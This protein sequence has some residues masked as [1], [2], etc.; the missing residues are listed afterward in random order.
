[1]HVYVFMCACNVYG[2][3]GEEAAVCVCVDDTQGV[4][5]ESWGSVNILS[6]VMSFNIDR[7]QPGQLGY[8]HLLYPQYC[9]FP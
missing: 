8:K 2:A 4:K 5:N 6:L 3:G 7:V 1:M 9:F